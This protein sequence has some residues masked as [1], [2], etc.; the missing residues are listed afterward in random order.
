MSYISGFP[1]A[2]DDE[3]QYYNDQYD[4]GDNYDYSDDEYKDEQE[5]TNTILHRPSIISDPVKLDVD[6]GMTIRLPCNVDKL[7]GN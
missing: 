5:D 2:R 1:N 4:E 6:N 7:P 3:L